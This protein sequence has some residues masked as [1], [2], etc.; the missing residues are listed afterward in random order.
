[1]KE[2]S[3][4]RQIEAQSNGKEVYALLWWKC[5]ANWAFN[6]NG[7]PWR[8]MLSNITIYFKYKIRLENRIKNS[9]LRV[10]SCRYFG[11]QVTIR[12]DSHVEYQLTWRRTT[13]KTELLVIILFY[14]YYIYINSSVSRCAKMLEC[15]NKRK[16]ILNAL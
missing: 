14:Y 10:L 12:L 9:R 7:I 3:A 8:K 1:M 6:Q 16:L 11:K 2:R 5:Y 13:R 4:L 15:K